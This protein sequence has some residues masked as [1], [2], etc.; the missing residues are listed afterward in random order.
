MSDK[1]EAL[2]DF[3]FSGINQGKVHYHAG[4]KFSHA[5]DKPERWSDKA[6]TGLTAKACDKLEARRLGKRLAWPK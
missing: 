5:A 4:I 3:E 6:T 2:Y 1:A